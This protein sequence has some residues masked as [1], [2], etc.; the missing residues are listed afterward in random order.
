MCSHSVSMSVRYQPLGFRSEQRRRYIVSH[1]H[2]FQ[3]SQHHSVDSSSLSLV[4]QTADRV[5][6]SSC[7]SSHPIVYFGT[8]NVVSFP[9]SSRRASSLE[10]RHDWRHSVKW[11]MLTWHK[12]ESTRKNHLARSGCKHNRLR[13][14]PIYVSSLIRIL[15]SFFYL[16]PCRKRHH[17]GTPPIA[18]TNDTKER[19]GYACMRPP[20]S[21]SAL[22]Q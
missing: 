1:Q 2:F 4:L 15:L 13:G 6:S 16:V 10:L 22:D 21:R 20:R 11:I 7:S 3:A 8:R 9:A 12:S 14:D 17:F 19:K 5:A 18:E